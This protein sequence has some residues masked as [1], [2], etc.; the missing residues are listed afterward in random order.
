M[1]KQNYVDQAIDDSSIVI[2]S[3]VPI[4][5]TVAGDR[6]KVIWYNTKSSSTR[7]CR[8]I[9]LEFERESKNLSLQEK[10]DLDTQIANLKPT[11]IEVTP[12]LTVKIKHNIQCSMVDGK[13]V[14]ALTGMIF[15][16]LMFCIQLVYLNM[17]R[18]VLNYEFSSQVS[19]AKGVV[20][21]ELTPAISTSSTKFY[22][23]LQTLLLLNLGSL[24]CTLISGG[25]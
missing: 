18:L 7:L 5:M 1:Y 22:L 23:S 6:N 9:K 10:K 14:S 20:C 19:H 13:V 15:H 21:V 3:L 8:P 2:T 25:I 11:V 12:S 16:T 4:Q 17:H 24:L